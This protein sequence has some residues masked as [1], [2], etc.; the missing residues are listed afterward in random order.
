MIAIRLREAMAKYK[1]RK[2][3]PITYDI[4]AERTG[5]GHGTLR[6]IGSRDD[7]NATLNVIEKLCRALEVGPGELLELIDDPPKPKRKAKKSRA[8]GTGRK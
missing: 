4:L 7:Y 6:T 2:R 5:I 1:R 8:R 3:A